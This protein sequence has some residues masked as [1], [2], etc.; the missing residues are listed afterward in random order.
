MRPAW[1]GRRDPSPGWTG[2]ARVFR[3]IQFAACASSKVAR[4][5][6]QP[7]PPQTRRRV[8]RTP[9]PIW[10]KHDAQP[11]PPSYQSA[12]RADRR[13]APPPLP[14]AKCPQD[15]A[16]PAR[17]F[18]RPAASRKAGNHSPAQ[19]RRLR[20]CS[21]E[22]GLEQPLRLSELHASGDKF[23]RCPLIIRWRHRLV[24]L[25]IEESREHQSIKA[26]REIDD[27]FIV[28]REGLPGHFVPV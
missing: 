17:A 22:R 8:S 11:M 12:L 19:Q 3:A 21:Q 9:P 18:L 26:G 7:R 20:N 27:S 24:E 15:L 10:P 6:R 14:G 13:L 4:A 23:A 5:F 2:A 28:Q 1:I 16:A 25:Q